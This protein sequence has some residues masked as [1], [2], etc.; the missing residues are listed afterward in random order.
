MSRGEPAS[1]RAPTAAAVAATPSASPL[2]SHAAGQVGATASGVAAA[3]PDGDFMSAAASSGAAD[4]GA[5]AHALPSAPGVVAGAAAARAM[6]PASLAAAAA[7]AGWTPASLLERLAAD[8]TLKY[9]QA[10]GR[11]LY[12]CSFHH[13]PSEGTTSP[14]APGP[15]SLR[16]AER[17]RVSGGGVAAQAI[18][19][20]GDDDPPISEA[21]KLHSRPG[22]EKLI[23]L[24]FQGQVTSGTLWRNGTA[25]PFRRFDMGEVAGGRRPC[26]HGWVVVSANGLPLHC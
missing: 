22:A 5:W 23:Y 21:F 1:N 2:A 16:L 18:T 26:W 6:S 7:S 14:A 24:N 10:A 11:L 12:A 25:V 15:S 9:D 17:A 13:G 20:P 8:P 19:P 3:I 4:G